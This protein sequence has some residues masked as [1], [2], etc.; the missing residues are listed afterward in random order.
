MVSCNFFFLSFSSFL[1]PTFPQFF[2]PHTSKE[3]NLSVLPLTS[4][5]LSKIHASKPNEYQSSQ[6]QNKSAAASPPFNFNSKS[7][8][9]YSR[10]LI[11]SLPIGTPP[12]AQQ[13]VLDTRSQ[14]S[15]IQCH[16]KAPR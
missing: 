6:V 7:P 8:F 5:H 15:W 2:P 14:L 11:V 12:Q 1:L 10:A 4:A 9:K 16:R 13:L 3:T